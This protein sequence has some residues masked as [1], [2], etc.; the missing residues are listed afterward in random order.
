MN[1][2]NLT[3]LQSYAIAFNQFVQPF[4]FSYF[5]RLVP[6]TGIKS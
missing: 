1:K 3:V 4:A 6:T 2:I 5:L